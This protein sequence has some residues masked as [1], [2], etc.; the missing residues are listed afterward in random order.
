[1]YHIAMLSE[2]KLSSLAVYPDYDSADDDYDYWVER[3]PNG[4]VEIL[5]EEEYSNPQLG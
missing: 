5:S 2:G 1:M 3:F 4:W